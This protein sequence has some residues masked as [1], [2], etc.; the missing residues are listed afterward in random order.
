MP[1]FAGSFLNP[2][3]WKSAKVSMSNPVTN[4]IAPIMSCGVQASEGVR[5]V[6]LSG[7]FTN[8]TGRLTVNT[9]NAC[10]RYLLLVSIYYWERERERCLTILIIIF[11]WWMHK[12][13]NHKWFTDI[14]QKQIAKNMEIMGRLYK[15]LIMLVPSHWYN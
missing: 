7:A 14:M 12:H 2:N 1:L 4:R 5:K 9:Q 3:F 13:I 15:L 10:K 11:Y 8:I 6:A